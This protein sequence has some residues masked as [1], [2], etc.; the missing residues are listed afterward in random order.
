VH[1]KHIPQMSDLW[2]CVVDQDAAQLRRTP[3]LRTWANKGKGRADTIRE[4][5]ENVQAQALSPG[6]QGLASRLRGPHSHGLYRLTLIV[7][8]VARTP[9]VGNA[10]ASGGRWHIPTAAASPAP[11][12]IAISLRGFYLRRPHLPPR[13]RQRLKHR[14]RRLRSL[15]RRQRLLHLL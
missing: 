3:L 8:A 4:L 13:R 9:A 12:T 14:L 1:I 5:C 6:E 11:T 7:A 15:M 2:C 10:C